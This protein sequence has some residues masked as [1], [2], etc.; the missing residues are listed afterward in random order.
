MKIICYTKSMNQIAGRLEQILDAQARA[1]PIRVCRSIEKLSKQLSQPFDSKI[2]GVFLA[3]DHKDLERLFAI[4]HLFRDI[5]IILIVPDLEETTL[6][7][8]HAPGPRFLS[9]ADDGGFENVAAVME[10][11]INNLTRQTG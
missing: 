5:P 6:S 11:M 3:V 8:G 10:K 1:Y 7:M 4:R 2:L 9:C